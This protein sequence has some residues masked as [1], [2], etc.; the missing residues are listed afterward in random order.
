MPGERLATVVLPAAAH[1]WPTL[2]A[3]VQARRAA[4]LQCAASH[5]LPTLCSTP[6]PSVQGDALLFFDMDV[7]GKVGDR[8]ALHASC[9]TSS[10]VRTHAFVWK[11]SGKGA[12]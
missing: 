5:T 2:R 10:G 8:S 6:H 11:G 9:P 1:T 4:V 7:E 3:P 12:G